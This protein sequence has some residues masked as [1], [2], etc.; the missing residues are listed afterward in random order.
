MHTLLFHGRTQTERCSQKMEWQ[1][2]NRV[3]KIERQL[4]FNKRFVYQV[5]FHYKL[6]VEEQDFWDT[7]YNVFGIKQTLYQNSMI[8]KFI[9]SIG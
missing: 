2:W 6:K 9:I 7:L 5:K 8:I 4:L 3:N 1:E